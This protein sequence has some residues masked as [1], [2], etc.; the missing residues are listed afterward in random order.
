MIKLTIKASP[1]FTLALG[2][3]LFW[4]GLSLNPLHGLG[5]RIDTLGG[6]IPHGDAGDGVAVYSFMFLFLLGIIGTGILVFMHK[7]LSLYER[8]IFAILTFIAFF[9]FAFTSVIFVPNPFPTEAIPFLS[10]LSV[11]AIANFLCFAALLFA[12]ANRPAKFTRYAIGS[13]VGLAM[14][15]YIL[16]SQGVEN[17][18]IL[19]KPLE[20]DIARS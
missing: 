5:Y 14:S 2:V 8:I 7:Q 4:I 19:E 9:A 6:R 13:V 15:F 18:Q 10:M 16:Y 12:A 20:I 1:Y 17:S 11:V 3:L